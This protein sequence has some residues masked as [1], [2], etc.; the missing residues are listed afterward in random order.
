MLTGFMENFCF[1]IG[2]AYFVAGSYPEDTYDDVLASSSH[3][4]GMEGVEGGL[5]GGIDG[6][7]RGSSQRT[8]DQETHINTVWNSLFGIPSMG[9]GKEGREDLRVPFI[10]KEQQD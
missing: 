9:K 2:S 7:S 10:S 6:T 4:G 8:R 3:G 1:L 5:L